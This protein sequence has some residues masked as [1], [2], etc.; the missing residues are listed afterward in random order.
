MALTHVVAFT[1]TDETTDA[2]VTGMLTSLRAWIGRGA[3]LEGL[4]SWKAG[5]DLALAEGNA[6]FG[7]SATFTDQAAYERY[8]DAP[9]HRRIITEQIAP[10]IAHRAGLQFEHPDD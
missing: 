5:P 4:V 6:H 10:H 7:V 9:E 8:R 1:W 3:E 2:D